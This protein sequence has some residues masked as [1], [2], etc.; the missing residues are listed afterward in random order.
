[1]GCAFWGLTDG[2]GST[3]IGAFQLVTLYHFV[4]IWE[5]GETPAI[6]NSIQINVIFLAHELHVI[7]PLGLVCAGND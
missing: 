4:P 3:I 5:R 7:L 6:G 1:M 2:L